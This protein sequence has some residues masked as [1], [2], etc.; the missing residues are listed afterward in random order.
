VSSAN[1]DTAH[2]DATFEALSD[3]TTL[4]LTASA[5]AP[6]G[7]NVGQVTLDA[8]DHFF[9]TVGDA[10]IELVSVPDTAEYKAT[11]AV[12]PVGTPI[13]FSFE[14]PAGRTSAPSSRVVFPKPFAL[15]D[16]APDTVGP[17]ATTSIVVH[18]S[19]V[20][21]R[22]IDGA[23]DAC[24]NDTGVGS[25]VAASAGGSATIEI[26]VTYGQVTKPGSCAA[27]ATISVTDTGTPDPALA[28]TSTV[29]VVQTRSFAVQ[30]AK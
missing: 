17:V 19:G 2:V 29:R 1:A 23:L 26:D 20:D 11:T 21:G 30:M 14:R 5:E 4:T 16:H 9:A 15:V 6:N 8:Q 12:P 28:P 7:T 3:G 13:V 18:A 10:K 25:R 24:T 22:Q 27:T